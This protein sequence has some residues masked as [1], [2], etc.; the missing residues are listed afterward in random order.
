MVGS[1]QDA[2][3]TECTYC[4][5][6]AIAIATAQ[7]IQIGSL[8]MRF[9]LAI[10]MVISIAKHLSLQHNRLRERYPEVFEKELGRI[11]KRNEDK[12]PIWIV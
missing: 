5:A 3:S 4:N 6:I 11:R 1:H 10:A 12:D 8:L 9:A 2:V 7:K